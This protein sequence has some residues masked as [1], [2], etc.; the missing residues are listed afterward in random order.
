MGSRLD[1]DEIN[2]LKQKIKEKRDS[3]AHKDYALHVC[4]A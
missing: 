1:D 4:V 2:F 3:P